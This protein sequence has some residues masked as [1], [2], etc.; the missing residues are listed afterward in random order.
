MSLHLTSG[1]V[2]LLAMLLGGIG[3]GRRDEAESPVPSDAEPAIVAA[4]SEASN[5]AFSEP[6]AAFEDLSAAEADP[7]EVAPYDF[8]SAPAKAEEAEPNDEIEQ[9]GPLT[10]DGEQWVTRGRLSGRDFDWYVFTVEGEPEL[11]LIEAISSNLQSLKYQNAAGE[12]KTATRHEDTSRWTLANLFLM[13]GRHWL[14]LWSREGDA[15]YTLRAVPLGAPSRWAEREPND[16][17]SRAHLLRLGTP[18]SGLLFEEGDEDYYQFSLNA[19][20]YV[21]LEV[22]PPPEVKPRLTVWE[23]GLTRTE[24]TLLL[25]RGHEAGGNLVYRAWLPSG[26]YITEVKAEEGQSA[27][28]YRLRV[29]R[30]DPFDLPCD[31]E[32]NDEPRDARPLPSSL[33]VTGTV[34][35]TRDEDWYRLPRLAEETTVRAE[36]LEQPD[37]VR[38]D[39]FLRLYREGDD[40]HSD[41]F[42]WDEE[43]A[44]FEGTLDAAT[45]W[46]ARIYGKGAYEVRFAFE[47]GPPPR[48]AARDLPLR[49]SL[50]AGPHVFAAFWHQDQRSQLPVGLV[51]ESDQT[52]HLTLDA[53]SSHHAWNARLEPTEVALAAGERTSVDLTLAVA[54]DAWAERPVRITIRARDGAGAQRTA[55]T[56][57]VARCGAPP[58]GGRPPSPLPAE[59]LGGL[60]V[61]WAGLGARPVVA[62]ERAAE[63]Q[64]PLHDGVTPNDGAWYTR[65]TPAAVTVELAGTEPLPVAGVV[66]NPRGSYPVRNQARRFELALSLDGREFSPVLSEE[67]G[68]APREQTFALDRPR[69]A[70]FARLRVLSNHE[71]AGGY[72]ALGEWKVIARPGTHPVGAEPFNLADPRKGGHVVWSDPLMTTSIIRQI[73]TEEVEHPHMRLDPLNPNR[74]IVG[75]HHQRAAQISALEWVQADDYYDSPRLSTVQV[76]VSAKSPVGPWSPLSTWQLDT[77]PAATSRLQLPE[78]IW[79]RYVRFSTTEPAVSDTWQLPETLRVFERPAAPGYLS[80]LGEWGQ[81]SRAAYYETTTDSGRAGNAVSEAGDNDT[82]ANAQSLEPGRR[83]R[84]DVLVGE[85]VDWYRIEVPSGHNRLELSLEGDPALRVVGRI[86]NQAGEEV[87]LEEVSETPAGGW[88]ADLAVEGGDAYFVQIVEP[89]RSIVLAWD[90]SGSTTPFKPTLYQALPRFVASVQ[91]EREFVNLLPFQSGGG[92]FLLEEWS[93]QAYVLQTALNDYDRRHGSSEAELALLTATKGLANRSGTRAV[94]FLTDADT[95]SYDKTG[96]LWRFLEEVRPRVFTLELHRGNVVYQQDL[97]QSWAAT[98]DGRYDFFR[99]NADL[100][101]AFDRA[102]CLLRRPAG[103]LLAATT[104]FEEPPGPGTIEITASESVLGRPAVELI[105]DASGSMLQRL[106]GRSRIDIAR[107]VLVSLVEETLPPET[108]LALRIF[109]HKTPRACQTDLEVPLS[110]LRPAK[111]VPVIRRTEAKNRA[112]T[113]IGASLELVAAD[114]ETADGPKIVI[115]V[116]DGE[117]TCGGDPQAAIQGL[118]D[119][120]FDVRVNI[121]GFAIEDETLKDTFS[122]WATLG[123]GLYFNATSGEELGQAMRQALQPKFQV[124]DAGGEVVAAGVTRGDPVEVP[125]GLYSVRVLTSPPRLFDDV[126]VKGEDSVVLNLDARDES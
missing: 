10:R 7:L 114:L 73:L 75:F 64:A 86:E 93:D 42:K 111:I 109:G 1:F 80:A 18:R 29:N 92:D 49:L 20:E 97:M 77:T 119:K 85:D 61:A 13:P 60:N 9:A 40:Y 22:A 125:A 81:Y 67:L 98:N 15:E 11:W 101:V 38:P 41:V 72:A 65:E 126:R 33:K 56:E 47:P 118:K 8:N 55:S 4:G 5:L 89:P 48:P 2:V 50:P 21:E 74:W 25:Y 88:R 52:L 43:N 106:E 120:G 26:D 58:I 51:N 45:P 24:R 35:E 34:G 54:E 112:K 30:L 27:S 62:D 105:L 90:N 3:C 37:N 108:P 19:A 39:T 110:P 71:G 116:T 83:Q 44:V 123:G 12:S 57:A 96:E 82:R 84:G 53:A 31:L 23:M 99:T 16:D 124:L 14:Q 107:D 95:H 94:V 6:E 32:P 63:D 87:S 17:P 79:A 28:P 70:R 59:L 76:S 36:I 66:L 115:L 78:P 113:P 100:E 122:R 46:I 117:E 68:P 91:S 121:V 102:S 103:Y 104:R 69:P